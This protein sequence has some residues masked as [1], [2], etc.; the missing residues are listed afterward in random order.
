[1]GGPF[2]AMERECS[3]T[4]RIEVHF[5]G[6]EKSES[7]RAARAREG[8]QAQQAFLAHDN[9]PCC[10]R[11]APAHGREAQG[12]PDQ[13]RDRRAAAGP[14]VVSHERKGSH[15]NEELPLAIRDAF[16]AAL[17]KVDGMSAKIGQRSRIERG[18]RRPSLP[19]RASLVAQATQLRGAVLGGARPGRGA[20]MPRS[21]D[22]CAARRNRLRAPAAAA[23]ARL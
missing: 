10:D 21:R 13:N 3:M 19:Q 7:N 12:L 11:G 9:V 4:H 14:S 5:H 2:T 22:R 16:D 23:D 20:G 1:M 17:R 18:R 8:R 15:A 6:I